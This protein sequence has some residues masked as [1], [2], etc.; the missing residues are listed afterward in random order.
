MGLVPSAFPMV[1]NVEFRQLL[2]CTFSLE[3]RA[4]FT[5]QYG[6]IVLQPHINI[7]RD[8]C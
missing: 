6:K 4:I 5:G 3:F 2:K 1:Q 7:K 8:F